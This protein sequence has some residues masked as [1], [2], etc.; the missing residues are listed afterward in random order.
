MIRITPA[1]GAAAAT[2]PAAAPGA[3]S[4]SLQ[5]AWTRVGLLSDISETF[6]EIMRRGH[7]RDL[8]GSFHFLFFEII[9][10]FS[11]MNDS[12]YEKGFGLQELGGE[13]HS[14]HYA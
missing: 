8:S 1:P 10:F 11:G 3:T 13:D 9:S 4:G 12:S 6:Y 5:T 7:R 2:S 14:I